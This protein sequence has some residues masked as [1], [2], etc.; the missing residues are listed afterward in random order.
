MSTVDVLK[1]I[2]VTNPKSYLEIG[3]H[4]GITFNSVKYQEKVGVD[5]EFLFDTA[6]CDGA[7]SRLHKM[8]SDKFWSTMP[9][10]GK[11]DLIFL[12]G[13]H[14]FEQTYRDFCA[15]IA[16]SHEKTIWLIDDVT[17]VNFISSLPNPQ[18][19]ARIRKLFRS[20]GTFWM[21]DVY[22]VIFAIHDF[23]PQYNFATLEGHG[24]TIVWKEARTRFKPKWNSLSKISNLGYWNYLKCRDVVMNIN[25]AAQIE[26]QLSVWN[27]KGLVFEACK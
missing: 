19:V 23:F 1:I 24:Q 5:P 12:D 7:T 8:T 15:S 14:T 26:R 9:E 6:V 13:L 4:Q 10:K 2:G 3:V 21:G 25:S 18:H 27:S 16:L 22:K 11:F 20:K 17:P